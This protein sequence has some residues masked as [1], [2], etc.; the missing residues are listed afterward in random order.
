MAGL[1]ELRTR[2]ESIKST[3]KITSAMKMVAAS[4]FRRAQLTLEKSELFQKMMI[5]NIKNVLVSLKQEAAEK[6]VSYML[7]KMLVQPKNPKVYALFVL[8]FRP[9]LVRQLQFANCQRSQAAHRRTAQRGQTDGGLLLR[10]KRAVR[11]KK[12][13]RYRNRRQLSECYQK[14]LNLRRGDEFFA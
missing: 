3:Q 5:G 12:A 6:G 4:K 13:R 9:G 14:T 7:P 10:Q 11:L 1:K 8:A 2:I